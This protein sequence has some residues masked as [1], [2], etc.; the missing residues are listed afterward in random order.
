V[1][2][3]NLIPADQR[4]GSARV[5]GAADAP[6]IKVYAV[7]GVLG[8]AL[9][10]VLALVLTSNQI[11]NKTDELAKAQNQEQ[12]VKQVADALRPYGQFAQI[13]QARQAQIDALVSTRF[14]WERAL[15][16]LSRAIP[17]NVWLI[18]LAGTISPAIGVE[19]AGGGGNVSN[20]REKANA[21]AFSI[22]GC[23][24][25]QHAV[26][27]MMT[28]M[29]NLDDVTDVQL[30]KSARKDEQ[31]AATAAPQPSSAQSASSQDTSDCTGSTRI[32]KFDML[33][34]FGGAPG[35]QAQGTDVS[36]AGGAAAASSTQQ[37]LG[38]AQS[39]ASSAQGATANAGTGGTP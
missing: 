27:R 23:T 1:R 17:D 6:P 14:D 39:A 2:P 34:V 24:Y 15:R 19:A 29:Q 11:N 21:P 36:A 3:V 8:V 5:A 25:S 13:Q 31:S 18:N 28:R 12:G 32:T 10:G 30:A 7:L 20:L 4:R 35:A 22:T 16:Q 9:L 26:A 33:V 38:K 37:N